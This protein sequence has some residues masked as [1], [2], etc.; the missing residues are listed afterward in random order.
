MFPGQTQGNYGFGVGT[1]TPRDPFGGRNQ[2]RYV[3]PNIS[4]E[5]KRAKMGFVPV[6][7]T[8]YNWPH[9]GPVERSFCVGMDAIDI[10]TAGLARFGTTPL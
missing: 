1:G 10:G 7:G 2:E 5:V 8:A 9:M 4:D 3:K 6:A